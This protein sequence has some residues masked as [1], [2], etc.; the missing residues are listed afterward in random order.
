MRDSDSARLSSLTLHIAH[1]ACREPAEWQRRS[2]LREAR[3]DHLHTQTV[4]HPFHTS[5]TISPAMAANSHAALL[6]MAEK[7]RQASSLSRSGF[8]PDS[9][10]SIDC[11]RTG[12]QVQLHIYHPA[13][14]RG[15]KLPVVVNWHGSGFVTPNLGKNAPFARWLTRE[16]DVVFVDADYAKAPE[17]PAPAALYECVSA[18]QWARAQPWSDGRVV[19][20][21]F[22]AGANLALVLSHRDTGLS[23]GL[24][25]GDL[26]ALKAVIAF[27]PVVDQARSD[28][29]TN[30]VPLPPGI[31]GAPLSAQVLAFFG[32]AYAGQP[33][34]EAKDPRIS[35][36]YADPTGF[37]V[38]TFIVSCSHDPL[39]PE[40]QDFFH[41]L[42]HALPGRHTH[43]LA[44]D[45]GHGFETRIPEF[46]EPG[47]ADAPGAQAKKDSYDFVL[48]G[49]AK[50]GI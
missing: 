29:P 11:T 27:Y 14:K 1:C 23:L 26:E 48:A 28:R 36:I 17:H 43:F 15:G 18:V 8:G 19:L 39:G 50:V 30:Q 47:F 46:N 31:P 2:T 4:R 16:R 12:N 20:S 49:L 42:D 33:P 25:Q 40:A 35:P 7:V 44:Q 32:M 6:A 24:T 37:T 3:A 9:K 22:S 34:I 21:G 41:K 45:T 38:P 10:T 5:S 13:S